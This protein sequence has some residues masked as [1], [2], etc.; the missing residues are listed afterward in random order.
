MKHTK[1]SMQ[2]SGLANVEAD[3]N[4]WPN[5]RYNNQD[6]THFVFILTPPY[7]GCTATASYLAISPHISLLVKNGEGQQLIPGRQR[8]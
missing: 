5:F 3:N 2:R 4:R 1:G 7:T 8:N 6:E